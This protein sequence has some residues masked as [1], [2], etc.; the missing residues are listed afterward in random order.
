[1]PGSYHAFAAEPEATSTPNRWSW[2]RVTLSAGVVLGAAA[3]VTGIYSY[4]TGDFKAPASLCVF[5]LKDGYNAMTAYAYQMTATETKHIEIIEEDA[6]S[7]SDVGAN[8]DDSD[9]SITIAS[10]T[11]AKVTCECPSSETVKR[12]VELIG[13]GAAAIS[14]WIGG[15]QFPALS[16]LTTAAAAITISSSALKDNPRA[17]YVAMSTAGAALVLAGTSFIVD[18]DSP[19]LLGT[20]G[21]SLSLSFAIIS[22]GKS[23]LDKLNSGLMVAS[24]VTQ[25]PIEEVSNLP[26]TLI[27]FSAGATLT[28]LSALLKHQKNDLTLQPEREPT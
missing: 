14:P 11:P 17:K 21:I 5:F 28:P 7:A 18:P 16:T 6:K 24:M 3:L 12:G 4:A 25:L 20:S 23:W 2:P 9:E 19:L 26:L 1:M 13:L 27:F 8:F 22:W 10:S 15:E